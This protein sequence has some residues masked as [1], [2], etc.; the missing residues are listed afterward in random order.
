MIKIHRNPNVMWREEEEVLAEAH[1]VLE[2]GE[3]AGG[4]GTA[5]LF[6]GGTMLS[7]NILGAEIWKQCDGLGV[8]EIV[9]GLL[10]R[11]EVDEDTLGRD[12]RAFL[13][14]LAE[15]GFITYEG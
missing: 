3:D 15:K 14:E 12:V 13:D 2:R 11:F 9:A 4:M 6:S 7:V 8:E 1:E 10:E 5:V